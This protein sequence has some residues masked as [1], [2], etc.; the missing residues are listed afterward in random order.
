MFELSLFKLLVWAAWA[1]AAGWLAVLVVTLVGL[2]RH[3]PLGRAA[4]RGRAAADEAPLV[5]VLVPARNEEGRVL[6][7]CVRSILAQDYEH[8]EVIAVN[9][10]STDATGTILRGLAEEDPRL[11]VIDGEEPPAGWLGKPFALQQALEQARGPW[12]LATDADMIFD[13]AALRT[14]L[15]YV[16]ERDCSALTFIPHF[17]ARS[18][19]ERVM[20]P[21]WSWV[22]LMYVLLYRVRSG[23]TREAVGIGGFFLM[24]RDVLEGVGGYTLLKDEVME[25][26]RL[27]ER[28][29][30]SGARVAFEY[31]PDLVTTRMYTNFR[32]M[33][34]C[35]T[36][37]WFS[38]MKFSA[39]LALAA[40]LAVYLFAVAPPVL[41]L[42]CAVGLA[43]GA[44]ANISLL[45]IP[46]ILCWAMQVIIL[47][48]VS[49][50]CGVPFFYALLTPLGFAVQYAMLL[51]STVR[52]V[53]GRGV[54]WKGRK[55]Y[56]RAGGV[57]PPRLRRQTP[58]FTDE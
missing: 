30:Q 52:I 57:R 45:L 58:N 14:A 17:E 42:A 31:A 35:S 48:A 41:A 8:F 46:L 10:R 47:A 53:S 23:R 44:D 11:R 13:R 43:T 12:V 39:G 16:W 15:D 18:F 2:A 32:E 7:A 37:N 26:M 1:C 20:I 22:M 50:R 36:K 29:K 34:E 9:D 28:L 6:A 25:D 38:G 49:R 27:A 51:D 19:W 40:V 55:I 24:R 33:W 4:R 3:K 54:T 56:E 5:S 21:T